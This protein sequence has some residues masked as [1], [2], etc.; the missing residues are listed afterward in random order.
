MSTCVRSALLDTIFAILMHPRQ[1]RVSEGIVQC[2]L[3]LAFLSCIFLNCFNSGRRLSL[4]VRSGL[5]PVFSFVLPVVAPSSLHLS[6][7]AVLLTAVLHVVSELRWRLSPSLQ[8]V[9]L[10]CNVLFLCRSRAPSRDRPLAEVSAE[11]SGALALAAFL[12][13]ACYVFDA[14]V[15]MVT[16]RRT[17]PHSRV[18][19]FSRCLFAAEVVFEVPL[20]S[21]VSSLLPSFLWLD[22]DSAS[23][24]LF[25]CALSDASLS[26]LFLSVMNLFDPCI[27]CAG[28]GV[29]RHLCLKPDLPF[30]K[31]L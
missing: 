8:H 25:Q 6:R 31:P 1:Q 29:Y 16:S 14:L 12:G 20:N 10:R 23:E 27:P 21:R 18:L 2:S 3:K 9:P 7:G 15:P 11:L 5:R 19:V 30:A 24:C 26:L 22:L 17:R 13:S 4:G 28:P